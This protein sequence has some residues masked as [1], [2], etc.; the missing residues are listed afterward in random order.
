MDFVL[1]PRLAVP[2]LRLYPA[3]TVTNSLCARPAFTPRIRQRISTRRTFV[4]DIGASESGSS[5]V[6]G[7]LGVVAVGSRS[8]TKSPEQR[9]DGK[10]A[11]ISLSRNSGL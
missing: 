11:G 3:F 5:V 7:E 2:E 6:A 1:L 10:K 9:L 4:R 8:A